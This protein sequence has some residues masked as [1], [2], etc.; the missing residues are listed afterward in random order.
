MT[1]ECGRM[2]MSIRTNNSDRPR[3]AERE[4]AGDVLEQNRARRADLADDLEVVVLH[5]HVRVRRR[6]VREERV[7]A[8]CTPPD[9]LISTRI[10][11]QQERCRETHRRGSSCP[12]RGGT[13][14]R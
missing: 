7:E 12:G 8:H 5:V 13:I 3:L 6:V 9:R 10:Y 4:G 11:L 1:Q 14:R 2:S